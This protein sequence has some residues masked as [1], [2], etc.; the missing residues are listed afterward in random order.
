MSGT[1]LK[2]RFEAHVE[3]VTEEL[4]HN[5]SVFF[6]FNIKVTAVPENESNP[7]ERRRVYAD[8]KSSKDKIW[9]S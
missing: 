2:F 6:M 5:G 8:P 3:Y 7:E 9:T 1:R 4:S